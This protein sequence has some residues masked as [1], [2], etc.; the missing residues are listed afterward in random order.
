MSSGS[1]YKI[2]TGETVL[3]IERSVNEA[4]PSGW[5][6]QGGLSVIYNSSSKTFSFFQAMVKVQMVVDA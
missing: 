6:P 1:H 5:V 2:L 3:E 4:F